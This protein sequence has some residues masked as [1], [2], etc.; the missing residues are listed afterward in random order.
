MRTYVIMTMLVV[1]A[2]LVNGKPSIFESF[3]GKKSPSDFLGGILANVQ[4][5]VDHF[6]KA[7]DAK[8]S[9]SDIPAP[10]AAKPKFCKK[11]ECPPF[12]VVNNS[13]AVYELRCYEAAKWVSTKGNGD[14]KPM[15]ATSRNMFKRLFAY[16]EGSNVPGKKIEMTV[17]VLNS[18]TASGKV[19]DLIMSFYIPQKFQD[20]TPVPRDPKVYIETKKFCAY[21]HSFKG[22]VISYSQVEEHALML[23]KA[24]KKDGFGNSFKKGVYYFAGYD[25]PWD[26]TDRHNEVMLMKV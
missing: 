6:K 5:I 26:F 1:M 19:K 11:R 3:F 16:I 14:P 10:V 9:S 13:S 22:F 17:P 8:P 4:K 18:A 7:K 12:T 2:T 15:G 20:E 21:V 23:K 24:L 25:A